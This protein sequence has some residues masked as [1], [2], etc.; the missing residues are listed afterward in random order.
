MKRF[1]AFYKVD[2]SLGY[3]RHTFDDIYDKPD[4]ILERLVELPDDEFRIYDLNTNLNRTGKFLDISDLVEDYNDEE[5][6]GGWWSVLLEY[7]E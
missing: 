6:D 5:L 2:N 4:K 3:E 1:L 7:S